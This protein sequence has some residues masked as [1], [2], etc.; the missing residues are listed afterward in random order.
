MFSA[1]GV[2]PGLNNATYL[3]LGEIGFKQQ[4]DKQ[5]EE[6][7]YNHRTLGFISAGQLIDGFNVYK[8]ITTTIDAVDSTQDFIKEAMEAII[9]GSQI[10]YEE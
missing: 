3:K 4:L 9:V 6:Y 10:P 1:S 2:T 8:G 7:G 5:K